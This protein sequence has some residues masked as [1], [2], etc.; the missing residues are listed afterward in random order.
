MWLRQFKIGSRLIAAFGLLALVLLLQGIMSLQ[1]MSSMR[2]TAVE[3]EDNTLPS[4]V[5]L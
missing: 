1:T 5:S 4:L 3:I 2:S